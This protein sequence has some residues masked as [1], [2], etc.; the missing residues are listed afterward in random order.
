MG[1]QA[2]KEEDGSAERAKEWR[3]QRKQKSAERSRTLANANE[4]PDKDKD[5]DKDSLSLVIKEIQGSIC[6]VSNQVEIDM[7][8]EWIESVPQE[9]IREAI[10]IAA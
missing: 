4:R 6:M 5:T 8:G 1:K 7:I 10:K 3:L 9:W 2:A